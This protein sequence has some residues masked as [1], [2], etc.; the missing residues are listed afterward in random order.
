MEEAIVAAHRA[1]ARLAR[2]HHCRDYQDMSREAA[3]RVIG[4]VA[5]KS[6]SLLCAPAGNSPAGLYGEL[7]RE[8][9]RK[10]DRFRRLRV[11]KLDE[12]LGLPAG[13]AATCE[14]FIRSRL[15]EPLAIEAERYISFDAETADPLRECARV[16]EEL[17]R[18]GPST[19]AFSAGEER[20]VGLN[21][22]TL[23]QPHCHV[24]N[25]PRKRCST[26]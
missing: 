12:W 26:R 8:A 6:D 2:I 14:H 25:C 3:A 18:Q 11:V 23:P 22:R 19:S 4:A 5:T 1:N 13:D 21:D 10:A 17:E 24:A 9:E 15:L 20:H 7:I 16:G